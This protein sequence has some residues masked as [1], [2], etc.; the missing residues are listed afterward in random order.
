M[1]SIKILMV[2]DSEGDILL[3]REAVEDLD[4]DV[5][6]DVVKDGEKALQYIFKEDKYTDVTTPDLILL[7]I[8]LPKMSGIEVLKKIK[9]DTTSQ[10]I[11]VIILSTSSSKNDIERAYSNYANCYI[12]KP[13]S[14]D[15]ITET[16]EA[17][18]SFWVGLSSLP[19]HDM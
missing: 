16:V 15:K 8:N 5:E 12:I 3:A 13:D 4:L 6:L 1:S 11:P 10:T 14:A 19:P 2:D 18:E 17:I 9:S 7:D